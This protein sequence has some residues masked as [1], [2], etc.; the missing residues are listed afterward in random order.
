MTNKKSPEDGAQR[1]IEELFIGDMPPATLCVIQAVPEPV[2]D[3][4]HGLKIWVRRRAIPTRMFH[5][6]SMFVN[7]NSG[8]S[9]GL[10]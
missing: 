2:G 8:R 9:Y 6:F 5:N 1:T 4:G 10:S 3:L 7:A